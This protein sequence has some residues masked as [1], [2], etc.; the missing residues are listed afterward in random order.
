[1]FHAGTQMFA[2]DGIGAVRFWGYVVYV[3]S[4][5]IFLTVFVI[6]DIIKIAPLDRQ[7]TAAVRVSLLHL[8]LGSLKK[9]VDIDAGRT[10]LFC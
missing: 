1:M 8:T 3:F 5:H 2:A 6:Y 7:F 10:L 9:G 4:F